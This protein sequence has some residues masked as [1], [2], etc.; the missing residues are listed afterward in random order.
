MTG[1]A[2]IWTSKTG[3]TR[4]RGGKTE[5]ADRQ[6]LREEEDWGVE[7]RFPG[8]WPAL[9]RAAWEIRF[10]AM[11]RKSG[12]APPQSKTLCAVGGVQAMGRGWLLYD[13]NT[14]QDARCHGRQDACRYK[15]GARGMEV[16]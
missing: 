16:G 12:G 3:F 2:I 1:A 15:G 4:R 10:L 14:G 5:W 6:E 7:K 11:R 9:G 13:S 8:N